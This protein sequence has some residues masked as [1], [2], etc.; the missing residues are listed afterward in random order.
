MEDDA[1]AATKKPEPAADDAGDDELDFDL[2]FSEETTVTSDKSDSDS[3]QS[4]EFSLDLDLGGGDDDIPDL[5]S[6]IGDQPGEEEGLEITGLNKK[7][8]EEDELDFDLSTGLGDEVETTGGGSSSDGG[9]G[10]AS[11]VDPEEVATK[12]DLARAYIDMGDEEGAKDILGEVVNEG[13]DE[14]K[15]EA[16]GLLGQIG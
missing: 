11:D 1:S 5:G 8:D 4:E 2:D 9:G 16:Q 14:Q 13:T 3:E 6:D 12:L 10:A 7:D 15:A